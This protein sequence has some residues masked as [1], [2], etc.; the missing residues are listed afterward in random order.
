MSKAESSLPKINLLGAQYF[1][2]VQDWVPYCSQPAK[3]WKIWFL[4]AVLQIIL[5]R[6]NVAFAI[7]MGVPALQWTSLKLS[8][9]HAKLPKAWTARICGTCLV[10]FQTPRVWPAHK[11]AHRVQIC[12]RLKFRKS[13]DSQGIKISRLPAYAYKLFPGQELVQSNWQHSLFF[14]KAKF[15]KS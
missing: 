7:I 1:S 14:P 2:N 4:K 15:F 6:Q 3:S 5:L 10:N 11:R 13:S 12:L 9:W 8:W